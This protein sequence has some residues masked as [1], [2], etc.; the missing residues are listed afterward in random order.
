MRSSL[1][2]WNMNLGRSSLQLEVVT[3]RKHILCQDTLRLVGLVGT[4]RKQV[5]CQETLRL[6]GLVG[7]SAVL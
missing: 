4:S 6:V 7:T 3:E 5:L 1:H 2:Q